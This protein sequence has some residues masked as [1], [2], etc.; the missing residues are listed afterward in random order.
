MRIAWSRVGAMVDAGMLEN[1]LLHFLLFE[2]FHKGFVRNDCKTKRGKFI[3]R[4]FAF[5]NELIRNTVTTPT[6][7]FPLCGFAAVR[8]DAQ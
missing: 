5:C 3:P 6:N 4:R 1:W 7:P 2:R 8:R